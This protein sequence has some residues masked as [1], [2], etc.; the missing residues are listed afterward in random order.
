LNGI[1]EGGNFADAVRLRERSKESQL[2]SVETTRRRGRENSPVADLS[3]P[4]SPF[5][6]RATMLRSF[7]HRISPDVGSGAERV[8]GGEDREEGLRA[9]RR[10][11]EEFVKDEAERG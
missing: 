8:E 1:D 10:M 3:N 2:P 6:R 5:F 9:E 4:I 11:D 7:E